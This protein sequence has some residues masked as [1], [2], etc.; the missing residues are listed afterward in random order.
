MYARRS[1]ITSIIVALLMTLWQYQ[2]VQSARGIPGS[3]EFGYGARIYLDGIQADA[4]IKAVTDLRLD[5]VA[6]DV[7]WSALYPTQTS[8][9]D[10]SRLDPFMQSMGSAQTA[11]MFSITTPPAWA[12]SAQGPN[13]YF[14]A[15][16]V[17][18]LLQRYP[19]T[20]QAI[21]LFPAPNTSAGWCS[22]P[23]PAAYTTLFKIVSVQARIITPN[24]QLVSGGLRALSP[25][26]AAAGMDDLLFLQGMY[27]AGAGA[28]INIIGLLADQTTSDPLAAPDGVEHRYLRHYEEVRAVMI[29]NNHLTAKLWLTRLSFPAQIAQPNDAIY[30]QPQYQAQWLSQAY[31]QLRSQLAVGVCFLDSLN[32]APATSGIPASQAILSTHPFYPTFKQMIQQNAVVIPTLNP[33]YAYQA[34]NQ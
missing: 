2:V 1:I 28:S 14:T 11:V 3:P 7:S 13:P 26:T 8:T 34:P 17:N 32:P 27:T 22:T 23:D 12:C 6:V 20:L 24:L 5:W 10:F 21:E 15:Q 19:N 16:L 25:Q 18:Q 29:K 33:T 9:P 4:A 31:N 30:A